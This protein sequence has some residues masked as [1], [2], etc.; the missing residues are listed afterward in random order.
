MRGVRNGRPV[1]QIGYKEL[2]QWLLNGTALTT[3]DLL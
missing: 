1:G 3:A 2:R